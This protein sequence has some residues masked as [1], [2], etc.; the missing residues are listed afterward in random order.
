MCD[1]AE[2]YTVEK[3]Q[4]PIGNIEKSMF[5]CSLDPLRGE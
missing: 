3:G 4:C 1:D 5:Y 2:A